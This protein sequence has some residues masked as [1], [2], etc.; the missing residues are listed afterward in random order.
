MPESF[1]TPTMPE[2]SDLD[3]KVKLHLSD[4]IVSKQ[5]TR[6]NEAYIEF[7]RYVMEYLCNRYV[8]PVSPV[9][10]QERI[11]KL[12]SDH[13]SNSTEVELVKSRVRENGSHTLLGELSVKL[14][15]ADD[16]YFATV[17]ALGSDR[18]RVS[19]LVLRDYGDLLLTSGAWGTMVTEYD[20]STRYPFFIR[21]F[22]P[23]QITQLSIDDYKDKRGI[24]DDDE[25]IDLLITTIGF[26]PD[27][28]TSREKW[29][30]IL[31]LVPFIESNYNFIEL[32]PKQTGKTY[33]FR[34]TSNNSVVI[35]GGT[36]TAATLFHNIGTRRRGLL[37]L[38][39]VVFFD[40]I[41]NTEFTN[42][43]TTVSLLK[44][45][46]QTGRFT[47]GPNSFTSTASIAM[48]G[49][50]DVDLSTKTPANYYLHYFTPLPEVLG[51][52]TAF[53]DRIHAYVPGW[54]FPIIQPAN[55]A[56]GFGFMTDYFAEILKQL[57]RAN[58]Q[59]IVSATV[60]FGE[61]TGRN[62][63]AIRKTMSGLI[64]LVYPH[65]DAQTILLDE[66]KVCLELSVEVRQRVIDQL[67]KIAPQEFVSVDL[68]SQTKILK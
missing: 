6:W 61:M 68:M 9:P 38:K 50:L 55:Y 34:N 53:L 16:E 14:F 65:R 37:L 56:R 41:A 36:A 45:Y 25:W 26:D 12:L 18:V 48:G 8:D 4:R 46:M 5:L 28:F 17:P 66:L 51:Q 47:R 19:S 24:F 21:E 35:S 11:D 13:Y 2:S 42:A 57:R 59:T 39:D 33:T 63:D 64:K 1:D 52:D 58:Y 49:N 20:N 62:Q 22:R 31:R 15:E 27:R 7:P 67:G 40:E 32:G 60:D 10:G 29:L 54:E 43:E 23:F 44:D 3:E 30:Y